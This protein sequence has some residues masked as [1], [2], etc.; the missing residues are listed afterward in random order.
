MYDVEILVL[1]AIAAAGA[2]IT[3]LPPLGFDIR[4]RGRQAV[5]LA[6]VESRRTRKA[7]LALVLA[8]LSLGLSAGAFYYFFHPRIVQKIVDGPV[9]TPCPEIPAKRSENEPKHDEGKPSEVVS[10]FL[11]PPKVFTQKT[12]KQLIALYQGRTMLQADKLLEPFKSMWIHANGQIQMIIPQDS[13]KAVVVMRS[14]DENVNCAFGEKWQ[15]ALARFDNGDSINVIGWIS[16]NQNGQ[17][18][19]LYDCELSGQ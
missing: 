4:I 13:K 5:P 19:Y 14:D 15:T 18:L 1:T 17:Q 8:V 16:P 9:S 2:V 10:G 11:V 3:A 6:P 12:V 7:W